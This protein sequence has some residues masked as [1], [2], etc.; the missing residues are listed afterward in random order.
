MSALAARVAAFLVAPAFPAAGEAAGDRDDHDGRDLA[1]ALPPIA[2]DRDAQARAAGRA[3]STPPSAQIT[4][5]GGGGAAGPLAVDVARAVATRERRR[6]A[7]TAVWGGPAPAAP[8]GP[9]IARAERL[10]VELAALP[11]LSAGAVTAGGT[12]IVVVLPA[13]P[14]SAVAALGDVRAAAGGDA[15]LVLVVGAPRPAALDRVLADQDV[16]AL[17]LPADA[18]AGLE[19]LAVEALGALAPGAAVVTVAVPGT[20]LPRPLRHRPLVRR[21][22]DALDGPDA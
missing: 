1:A 14:S 13:D 2:G 18:V 3:A 15:S 12:G 9:A 17:V 10:A 7:V 8:R 21:I 11:V 20:A 19:A 22:V 6:V 5:L 4:L 16:I